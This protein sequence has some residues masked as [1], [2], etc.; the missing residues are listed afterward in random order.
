MASRGSAPLRA[1]GASRG[2]PARYGAGHVARGR[3]A[4][5]GARREPVAAGWGG[6]GRRIERDA[7]IHR[8]ASTRLSGWF[9]SRRVASA[10]VKCRASK[11]YPDNSSILVVGGGG[12][13]IKVT[14]KLKDMG[15]WVWMMQRTDSRRQEIEN[16]MA[17][18][19]NGDATNKEDVKRVFDE[20]DDLDAVVTTVGGTPANPLSDSLGNI[21]LIEAAVE[22]GVKRF[23]LVT[24]IGTGDSKN[25]PPPQVYDVLRPVLLEKEKA[26]KAL[27]E[28]CKEGGMEFVILRP[29]GL[30]TEPETHTAVLTE[31]TTVC[32]PINREDMASL[33]CKCLF[34]EA[35]KNRVF[36]AIDMEQ[37]PQDKRGFNVVAM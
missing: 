15:A 29:G 13:A 9:G 32:G 10:P 6:A 30:K 12:V 24:S 35:S 3:T 16:M 31:D 21:N 27:K 19:V 11:F 5:L 7:W 26:E 25:A 28:K 34:A 36:S 22:K 23:I 4:A 1:G 8:N 17:I 20:I 33:V 18:V 14:R 2:N 37:L